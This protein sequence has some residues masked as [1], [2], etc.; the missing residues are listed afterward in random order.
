MR[1]SRQVEGFRIPVQI[2][3]SVEEGGSQDQ[4]F[5]VGRSNLASSVWSMCGCGRGWLEG[6]E[7]PGSLVSSLFGLL[8]T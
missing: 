4:D 1:H 7:S 3:G 5:A 2:C 8:V 6:G